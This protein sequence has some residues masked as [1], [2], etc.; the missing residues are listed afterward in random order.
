MHLSDVLRKLDVPEKNFNVVI[1]TDFKFN[2]N[3]EDEF[4]VDFERVLLLLNT[5]TKIF[6]FEDKMANAAV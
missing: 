3:T 4:E 5:N 1:D 2:L 6:A